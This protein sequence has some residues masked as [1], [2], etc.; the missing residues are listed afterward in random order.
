MSRRT[1]GGQAAHLG[2][3]ALSVAVITGVIIPVFQYMLYKLVIDLPQ[4]SVPTEAE[5]STWILIFLLGLLGP[6]LFFAG[7][8]KWSSAAGSVGAVA[9]LITS[10]FT[11]QLFESP[12]FAVQGVLGVIFILFFYLVLQRSSRG[13]HRY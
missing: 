9:F 2:E 6:A 3:Q 5:T 10:I 1:A 4:S 11:S 7:L 12:L 8:M 13:G